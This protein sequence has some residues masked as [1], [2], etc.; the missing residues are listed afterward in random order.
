MDMNPV[1]FG[2][3]APYAYIDGM[4]F[5]GHKFLGGCGSPGVLIAKKAMLTPSDAHP[6][7]PGI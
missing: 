7:Q 2:P 3:D 5:S 4:Y 6:T 1:V